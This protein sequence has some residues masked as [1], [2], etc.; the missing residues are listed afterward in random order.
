MSNQNHEDHEDHEDHSHIEEY[1]VPEVE[2]T[3]SRANMNKKYIYKSYFLE[4]DFN[5]EVEPMFEEVSQAAGIIK[6]KENEYSSWGDYNSDGWP[7]LLL[8]WHTNPIRLYRNNQDGTFTDVTDEVF[9]PPQEPR[10]NHGAVWADFDNDGD[11]DL[12]ELVGAVVGTGSGPKKLYVNEEGVLSDK[13]V[14]L[15]VDYPLGRGRTPS[16]V[17]FDQD[18]KLDLIMSVTLRPDAQAPSTIFR[19][20]DN[21]F[22]DVGSTIGFAPGH[23]V[24]FSLL[25]DLSGDGNMDLYSKGEP[26]PQT[27][28]DITT[29]PLTNITASV[30]P[31]QFSSRD[32]AIADFNNDLLP[33]IYSTL[34]WDTS[35]LGQESPLDAVFL[36]N[37]TQK[38]QQG[39]QFNTADEATFKLF[40]P[41]TP[42]TLS[43]KNVYV[44][45]GGFTPTDED[46]STVNIL[47]FTLSPTDPNVAGI[48]PYTPGTNRGVYVGYDP[49]K[50]H[51]QLFLSTPNRN[52]VPGS[53]ETAEPISNLT[54]IGFKPTQ[55]PKD[56]LFLNQ[57]GKLVDKSNQSGINTIPNAGI[58]VVAGDF[59][60]DMDQDIYVVARG[61]VANR[62][63]ILYEN[64]GDG[65]FIPVPDASGAAGSNLGIGVSVTTADY[66]QNGFLDLFVVNNKS[67]S[68]VETTPPNQ[69]FRNLGNDNHWLQID[70]QG[71]TSNLDAIGAQVFVTAG[72]I[73]Q[74]REQSG[75]IHK[76]A[77]NYQRLHFGLADNTTVDEL[78]IKWPSGLEQT[79]NN[80]Q[81]DQ[82]LKITETQPTNIIGEVGEINNLTHRMQ[83]VTL[84]NTYQ[85]PVVIANPAS[86][87]EAEPLSVAIKNITG[88]SFDIQIVEPTNLNGI[89]TLE[90]ISYLVLEAGHYELTDGTKVQAGQ[91]ITEGL[92]SQKNWTKVNF[93]ENFTSTPEVFTQVQD[94]QTGYLN[95]RQQG[96]S[97][98]S[99]R[100]GV[101]LQENKNNN[102]AN[103][104]PQTVG[105]VAIEKGTGNW[106]GL[107]YEVANTGKNVTH[108]FFNQ[109]FEQ[110]FDYTPEIIASLATYSGPDPAG[111]RYQN[112]T[113]TGVKFQVQEDTTFDPE[114]NHFNKET[115]SFLAIEGTG[116]LTGVIWN[117]NNIFAGSSVN[118]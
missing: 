113:E 78:L 107:P 60:N 26:S 40:I 75:G 112:L 47:E 79:L 19:Q 5:A 44:G 9:I 45:A 95:T 72:G 109:S 68:T 103:I 2:G 102:S 111:L 97:T 17:D 38:G 101:E 7:D 58:S 91:T 39:V 96:T 55:D 83:K 18:G 37:V 51:W 110:T 25:S 88:N 27:I 10:D 20:T 57:A 108:N 41:K 52:S 116:D 65:T 86:Y 66:D 29:V 61:S 100:V 3:F 89:H 31:Q 14:E 22:E 59:D 42:G 98:N 46:R 63:N 32:V 93:E 70:L 90:D 30:L 73:T 94:N 62:P 85:N 11:Q 71:V 99:F 64:Q 67:N 50:E 43:Q 24:A 87:N 106:N 105:W 21:G 48:F 16:W 114:I 84:R 35:D 1:I 80:I 81:A 74:L 34:T 104:Q 56:Q 23:S 13:A 92:A 118:F 77:Q 69:L 15:G 8:T 6:I 33:D 49:I 54:A 76:S 12:V 115:V 53:I 28:Y 4:N 36:L 82:I 117:E